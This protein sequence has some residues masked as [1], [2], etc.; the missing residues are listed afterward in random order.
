MTKLTEILR[1][2]KLRKD[3]FILIA[4]PCVI[5]DDKSPFDIAAALKHLADSYRIPLIFKAS[6]RKANRSRHDSFTGIGDIEALEI[7]KSVSEIHE[8]PVITDVHSEQ[9]VELVCNYVD[10]LQI[11]AFL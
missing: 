3:Q 11:P 7:L 6:Y 5:E 2:G 4:G 8:I 10:I 1:P 9:D